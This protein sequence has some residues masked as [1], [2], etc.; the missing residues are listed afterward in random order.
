MADATKDAAAAETKNNGAKAAEEKP[1]KLTQKQ[2]NAYLKENAAT[3]QDCPER[4]LPFVQES[5]GELRVF[6]RV[7]GVA[8]VLGETKGRVRKALEELG[9]SRRPFSYQHSKKGQTSASY[10]SAPA[11]TMAAGVKH[12]EARKARAEGNA[13]G[14]GEKE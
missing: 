14:S 13:E 11:G 12:R 7:D 10:Y 2:V 4:G 3:D 9:F 6:L 1:L 8:D 5:K